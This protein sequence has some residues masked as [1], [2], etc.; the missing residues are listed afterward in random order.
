MLVKRDGK[1]GPGLPQVVQR[2]KIPS[3]W[4]PWGMWSEVAT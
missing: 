1:Q 2:K 3:L 4:S